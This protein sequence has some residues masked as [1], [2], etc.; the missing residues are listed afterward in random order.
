MRLSFAIPDALPPRKTGSPSMWSRNS[1]SL[2]LIKLRQAAYE[3]LRDQTPFRAEVRLW[4]TIHV[5]AYGPRKGDL[6]AYLGG[7][8]DG[9]QSATLTTRLAPIWA[10]PAL[11]AIH[12][13]RPLLI[14]DDYLVA[15]V[16]ADKL[17]GDRRG[18]RVVIEDLEA[19]RA[20]QQLWASATNLVLIARA[21]PRKGPI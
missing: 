3:A 7:V 15:S 1:E 2:R 14:V 21:L 10:D 19:V 6:D 11:A 20:S 18:Y 16:R 8:F 17:A 12:P 4:L 5:D 13:H 9:L